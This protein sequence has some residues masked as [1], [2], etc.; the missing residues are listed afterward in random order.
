VAKKVLLLSELPLQSYDKG[1]SAKRAFVLLALF[2]L[3]WV[4]IFFFVESGMTHIEPITRSGGKQGMG[5]FLMTSA[6]A[7]LA[8]V[9]SIVLLALCTVVYHAHKKLRWLDYRSASALYALVSTNPLLCLVV[10]DAAPS[11]STG[12]FETAYPDAGVDSLT[13]AE[14]TMRESTL[15]ALRFCMWNTH[16]ITQM[17]IVVFLCGVIDVRFRG[18]FF[19][20]A[21]PSLVDIGGLLAI[22]GGLI[23]CVIVLIWCHCRTPAEQNTVEQNHHEENSPQATAFLQVERSPITLRGIVLVFLGTLAL[24]ICATLAAFAL[25]RGNMPGFIAMFALGICV[26]VTVLIA[27]KKRRS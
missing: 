4:L 19:H 8:T 22:A 13:P 17:G 16:H 10:N 5:Y 14:K 27:R 6:M 2:T 15:T 18:S 12:A 24:I 1:K 11:S 9:I 25:I 7:L 20:D 3:A 23:T 26:I 21:F